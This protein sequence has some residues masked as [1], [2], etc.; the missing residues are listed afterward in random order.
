MM[1]R[2]AIVAL[3]WGMGTRDHE[4]IAAFVQLVGGCHGGPDRKHKT[5]TATAHPTDHAIATGIQSFTVREEWYYRLK[6]IHPPEKLHPVLRVPIDGET[7]T[8]SWAWQRPD[9]GRSFGFSGLHYHDNWKRTEYRRLVVQGIL[10]SMKRQIPKSGWPAT[11]E[12]KALK[13]E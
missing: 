1:F 11:L 10:W 12:E 7:E 6:F 5:V 13:L 8:V 2:C 9:G 3:H 4:N